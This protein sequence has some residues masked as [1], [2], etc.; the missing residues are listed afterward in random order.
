MPKLTKEERSAIRGM[1]NDGTP[2]DQILAGFPNLTKANLYYIRTHPEG[3]RSHALAE[4]GMR[5][6][7]KSTTRDPKLG[8]GMAI[9]CLDEERRS[10]CRRADELNDMIGK[11]ETMLAQELPKSLR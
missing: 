4:G 10:L 7:K 5:G 6:A 11:L 9:D 2:E 1:I 8:L 3:V